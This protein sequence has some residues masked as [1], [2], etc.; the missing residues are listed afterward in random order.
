MNSGA[1]ARGRIPHI[2]F[3]LALVLAWFCYQPAVT[4]DFQLDDRHNLEDLLSISDLD[5]A[6][7]FAL[8]GDAGP[9]GRPIALLTFAAQAESWPQDAAD[10]I[11]VNILI[12]LVNAVLLAFCVYRLSLCMSMER[13]RAQLNAALV[14][15]LWVLMPLLATASLLV[16][17]RMTTLSATFALLGLAGYLL[18]RARL[19]ARPQFALL[20][21]SVSLGAGTTLS[22]FCKESGLLLPV[23]VLA[24]ELT[25]LRRPENI[26]SKFWRG[27]Q[28]AC[29][30]L[31]LFV[32]VA[33]LATIVPYPEALVLRRGFTGA[34][35]LLTEAH[36]LWIYLAK[37]VLGIP[38]SLGIFQD[39][40]NVARSL[41]A[42]GT[43]LAVASWLALLA[44]ALVWRRRWP[45][46]ALAILWF[47]AG[48]LIE[49]TTVA[50]ELY[51]EHRNYLPVVGPL[52]ALGSFIVTRE[53]KF[54]MPG[55]AALGLLALVNAYF[56]YVFAALWGEPSLAARYWAIRYPDSVR[57]VTTL[58][59]YQMSEESALR[60]AQT[61]SQFVNR[62][63][64]HAYL[65]I[66][67]LNILC[68]IAAADDHAA[69]VQILHR[70]LPDAKFT[71]TAGTMLSQLFDASVATECRSVDP[72]TVKQ[73]AIALRNNP[74]YQ[75]DSQYNQFHHKLLAGIARYQ[76]DTDATLANLRTAIDYRPSAELNF[77]MVT[78]LV[79]LGRF[80][81][82]RQFMAD[83]RAAAPGNPLRAALWGRELD[84]LAGYVDEMEN[85]RQ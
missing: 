15:G 12:H 36:I 34:E 26:S 24:L 50:L 39:E 44:G 33:Y 2:A 72:G 63:P 79:D 83:A 65:R 48:H 61:L 22:M 35:R 56:L 19:D 45:L 80:A 49:S 9:L 66:Q 51:F 32:I 81:A 82:A 21:M 77:M 17:Q 41:F 42:P 4:G 7:N 70:Q 76:G 73:L 84:E 54:R 78:A 38:G 8:A 11:R 74:R 37:G 46:A 60:A 64:Q 16:V 23:F 27:W 31:P 55:L 5:S 25:V 13:G 68:R 3:I 75:A 69:L 43:F 52:F 47:L 28:L 58:A 20:W 10:F 14:A 62:N 67:E 18:A 71:Y 29:L 30:G 53:R 59:T 1:F 85:H 6:W 40:P 57:A